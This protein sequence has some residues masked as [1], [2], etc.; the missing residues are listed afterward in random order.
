MRRVLGAASG[1]LLLT[2][3]AALFLN[4]LQHAQTARGVRGGFGFLEQAA[5]FRMAEGL[6]AVA[7]EQS[8]ALAIVAGL[9]NTLTVAAIALPGA[10]LLGGLLGLMRLSRHPLLARASALLIEPL[11]NTPVLLQLF[12]WYGL[13]LN[14]PDVRAAWAPL[15]YVLLSNRGLALP[16]LH[17]AWPYVVALLGVGGAT[18]AL[19]RGPISHWP[20]WRG[21]IWR[22]PVKPGS[23]GCRPVWR[24]PIWRWLVL[25]AFVVAAAA[26]LWAD[27]PA[28]T[29]DLPRRQGFGLRGGA[30]ISIEFAALTLGLAV[31][32][33]AYVADIVRG[34]VR[35]V[36]LGL[37]EAGQALALTP[38]RLWRQVILPNAARA[39]LPPYANQCL[40]VIKNSTLAIAIGYQD[41]MAVINT[42]ITQ[43]GLALEG[44]TLATGVY[45]ALALALG[46]GLAAWNRRLS[47]Q[48]AGSLHGPRWG[49]RQPPPRLT[50]GALWGT[51]MRLLVTTLTLAPLA[52][53]TW[54]LSAWAIV[55][56]VWRDP[57]V[58]AADAAGACW[59][60]VR[61]NLPLLIYGT[62]PP[63]DRPAA[64]VAI[65]ALAAGV[66]SGALAGGRP[67]PRPRS[68]PA[69]LR[70]RRYSVVLAAIVA[71]SALAGWPW[72]H[73]LP[74]LRWNG[75][76]ATTLL[77][78][79]ALL[80]ALPLSMLLALARRARRAILS[81][82]ATFVIEAARGVPMPAQLLFASFVLP[83]LFD[84][85]IAKFW[86]ALAALTL[87]TACLLAEVWR[88]ALQAVPAG[89]LHA[90]R[91]LGMRTP[92]AYW[93]VIWPQ[94][95]RIATPAALGVFV[96]AVKDTSLV[97]IIGVF[98]LLGAAKAVIADT[99]WRPYY[100]ELYAAV[101][102]FYFTVCALLSRAARR[103]EAGAV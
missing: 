89:Q 84:G 29:L 41:L 85:G 52:W 58:C 25:A 102:L 6:F 11:R 72:G 22:G 63:E 91:A 101:A 53:L 92:T 83:L 48:D 51:P 71:L 76:L 78:I 47:R 50:A 21:S 12:V 24:R 103:A 86:M 65:L 54:R 77:A 14:L 15:P 49:A 56:A 23:D 68:R 67:R 30:Q 45:L 94:A 99:V 62:M 8:Y 75:L 43:T 13:L 95:R 32:H 61:V 34:A 17:G 90:A 69:P 35:A 5:G 7:P 26:W 98:D 37:V 88:G 97:G 19:W 28:L 31:F 40:A 44:M 74:V 42:A 1:G 70:L 9:V 20:V 18:W 66:W 79:A 80:L 82:P 36:P 100:V 57:V 93:H 81:W 2:A 60:A 38:V 33:A 96:G 4:Y 46:T 3:L 59:A 16:A 55:D 10:T 64:T 73:A 87:H 27:A 39:G